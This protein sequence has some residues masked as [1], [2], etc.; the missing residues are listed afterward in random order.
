ML[1]LPPALQQLDFILSLLEPFIYCIHLQFDLSAVEVQ[2][3]FL[4]CSRLSSITLLEPVSELSS[5][6]FLQR[7]LNWNKK[8]KHE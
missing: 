7:G 2:F 3:V 4:F 6:R 8:K 1:H 5:H